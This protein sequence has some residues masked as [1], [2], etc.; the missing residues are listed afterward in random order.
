MFK[1]TTFIIV[2]LVS[3][4]LLGGCITSG[5]LDAAGDLYTAATI[6]KE[7]LIQLS[8]NMR[9]QGDKENKVAT[10]DNK[11]AVRL[12]RLTN[13]LKKEDGLDLNFK[14]Y[15]AK[16]V[17]ANATAD[18][19]IRVY[20]GL[21]DMMTDNELFFVIG[22]EVGHVKGGDSL[23]KVRM[24]YVSSGTI[25]AASA[26]ASGSG[27]GLSNSQLSGLL[28]KALNAQFS[29]SQESDADVYGYELMKKYKVDSKAAVSALKK[30]NSLGASGG[31]MSSHPNS[32]DR[33]AAIQA[34]IDADKK[35]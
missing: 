4:G 8:K 3:L 30:L 28:Y 26:L 11:Y 29:Q 24:A 6:S 16:D 33:A 18:G 9:A 25:K 27:Y 19:S 31:V 7:E 21:M 12:A 15:I 1:R 22:H 32:G 5:H 23:D 20:T 13:K 14:A 2:T 34:K 10:G 35:K 17:N